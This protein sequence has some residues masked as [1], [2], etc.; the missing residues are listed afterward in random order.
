MDENL[1]RSAAA[2]AVADLKLDCRVVSVDKRKDD[3]CVKFSEKYG[4]LCDEFR[5]RLGEENSPQVV[6]E[7]IK[8]HLLK[9]PK[10]TGR[11][12]GV[13][14]RT[15]RTAQDNS[16]LDLPIQLAGGALK[17]SARVV[18][19]AVGG[20]LEAAETALKTVADAASA[21]AQTAS[22]VVPAPP[23]LETGVSLAATEPLLP[24]VGEERP[25]RKSTSKT[26]KSAAKKSKSAAKKPARKSMKAGAK[27]SQA[28][29]SKKRTKK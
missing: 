3:W 23:T 12:K 19:E 26:K 16:L 25:L 14:T 24:K 6:R 13:R 11:R 8:R 1:I 2:E 28:G 22:Q 21:V 18:S 10:P 17:E 7:K 5:S 27:R 4:E 15:A 9:A 20:T 29:G